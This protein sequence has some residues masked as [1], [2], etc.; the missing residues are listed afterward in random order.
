MEG[1]QN[2]GQH[3]GTGLAPF[4]VQRSHRGV[5]A[6]IQRYIRLD[7]ES[8][9]SVSPSSKRRSKSQTKKNIFRT[10]EKGASNS[11]RKMSHDSEDSRSRSRN[12]SKCLK[13]SEEQK[14]HKKTKQI[15][16]P[17]DFV[18]ILEPNLKVEG[19]FRDSKGAFRYSIGANR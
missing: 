8:S 6:P 7:V 10:P 15:A 9:R 11:R 5:R 17:K 19:M 16:R 4:Q 3:L 12:N 1:L 13:L 14:S 18:Q 2:Q